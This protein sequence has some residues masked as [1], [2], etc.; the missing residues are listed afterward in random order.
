MNHRAHHGGIIVA[1]STSADEPLEEEEQSLEQRDLFGRF[2]GRPD[3]R[4]R[5]EGPFVHFIRDLARD[6]PEDAVT[7]ID[8]FDGDTIG[9]Y[10]IADD[11]LPECTGLSEDEGQGKDLLEYICSGEIDLGE[12]LRIRR[13]RDEPGY[14]E[15][16]SNAMARARAEADRL[17]GDVLDGPAFHS[18]VDGEAPVSGKGGPS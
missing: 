8:S 9:S 11:T 4:T 15:W 18:D 7:V 1:C 12:C 5:V 16:L 13:A 14:R 10:R 3:W 6:P 17:F 2:I